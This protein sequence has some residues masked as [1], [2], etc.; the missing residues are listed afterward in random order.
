M[1]DLTSMALKDTPYHEDIVVKSVTNDL[2][3]HLG[4]LVRKWLVTCI[5]DY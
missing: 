5:S 4:K 2:T 3:R 1:A